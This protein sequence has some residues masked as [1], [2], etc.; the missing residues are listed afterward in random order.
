[1]N[2]IVH[3]DIDEIIISDPTVGNV[4]PFNM[5]FPPL[6]NKYMPRVIYLYAAVHSTLTTHILIVLT[7]HLWK[8]LVI[9][10]G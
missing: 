6:N 3:D 8:L 5:S 9:V 4:A 1:M 7:C 2:A 10:M